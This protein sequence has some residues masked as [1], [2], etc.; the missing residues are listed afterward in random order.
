MEALSRCDVSVLQGVPMLFS[1][2]LA[3]MRQRPTGVPFTK[4][5]YLYA[6]GDALDP[7]LKQE[8]EA[9][10]SCRYIMGME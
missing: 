7:A 10:T 9:V 6:G 4:L 1:R 8:I 2:L 5:R 3:H